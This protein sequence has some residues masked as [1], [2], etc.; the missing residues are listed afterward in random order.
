[1]ALSPTLVAKCLETMRYW[2]DGISDY[3]IQLFAH[4]M[5]TKTQQSVLY[6][7]ESDFRLLSDPLQ[8]A[9]LKQEK[10]YNVLCG[11]KECKVNFL[12][13]YF[14]SLDQNE[15]VKL[16]ALKKGEE[17]WSESYSYHLSEIDERI[18]FKLNVETSKPPDSEDP[19]LMVFYINLASYPKDQVIQCDW[20]LAVD[21]LKWCVNGWSDTFDKNQNWSAGKFAFAHRLLQN[22]N[23]SCL[24]IRLSVRFRVQ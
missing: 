16:A 3:I 12:N 4:L 7:A 17:I 11:D 19:E 5:R 21:E 18:W 6:V 13:E 9:L 2:Y 23:V 20:C 10:G 15:F 22:D 8:S 1:M 14:W 24:T